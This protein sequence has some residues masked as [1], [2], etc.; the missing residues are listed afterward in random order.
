VGDE[1]FDERRAAG[2]HPHRAP[3]LGLVELAVAVAVEA[4]PDAQPSSLAV[5]VRPAQGE[6]FAAPDARAHGRQ[7]GDVSCALEPRE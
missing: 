3:G 1:R 5:E 2:D 7:H 4:A 6:Q